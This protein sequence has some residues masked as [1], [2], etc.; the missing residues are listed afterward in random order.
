MVLPRNLNDSTTATVLSMM[1][2]QFSRFAKFLKKKR[3]LIFS[4]GEAGS[5]MSCT[6]INTFS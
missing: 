2:L 6:N 4:V 3:I 1:V 5:G